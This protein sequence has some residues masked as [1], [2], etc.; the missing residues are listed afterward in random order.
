MLKLKKHK[1][2]DGNDVLLIYFIMLSHVG[3]HFTAKT[4]KIVESY[5]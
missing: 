4:K 5:I 1:T 3:Y 2:S